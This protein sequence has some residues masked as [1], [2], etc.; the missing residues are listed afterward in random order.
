[1]NPPAASTPL[2]TAEED[3]RLRAGAPSLPAWL[4][5]EKAV[6]GWADLVTEV[7]A[8]Y[9]LPD[10]EYINDVSI[11]DLL[12]DLVRGA[13]DDVGGRLREMLSPVDERFV[14]ATRPI[15]APLIEDA[16]PGA[17]WWR[18]VPLRLN[19]ELEAD[20]RRRGVIGYASHVSR[21]R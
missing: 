13:P 16:A 18:R 6:R 4:T 19:V 2:F 15:D 21:E 20:L 10:Y 3:A 5:P 17:F 14:R 1:M 8:E 12:D 9:A 7:E 11:R